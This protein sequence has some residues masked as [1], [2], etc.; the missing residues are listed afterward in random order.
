[1]ILEDGDKIKDLFSSK[2]QSF[3]AELPASLWVG[4][5]Q[6]LSQQVAP[7]PTGS[8][9]ASTSSSSSSSASSSATSSSSSTSSLTSTVSTVG[10]TTV[11]L[12]PVA[13]VASAV[14]LSVAGVFVYDTINNDVPTII[15]PNDQQKIVR[16]D[17][18]KEEVDSIVEEQL[19][20]MVDSFS[21]TRGHVISGSPSNTST[22]I[23][24]TVAEMPEQTITP[25]N[26][27][28]V[29]KNEES[30]VTKTKVEKLPMY[31]KPKGFTLGVY[32]SM[33]LSAYSKN[34]EGN[35]LT[36][37]DPNDFGSDF[38][39]A[40]NLFKMKHSRPISVGLTVSKEI[41]SNLSI[42]TGVI[43]TFLSS[44]IEANGEYIFREKQKFHY[45]GIPIS[46]NYTFFK[47]NNLSLYLSF[48]GMIQKDIKGQYIGSLKRAYGNGMPGGLPNPNM[49]EFNN[50]MSKEKDIHQSN[51]QFS[52]HMNLGITYPLY[53]GLYIYGT[54]G[55][56]YYFDASNKYRT[57]Y[58]DKSTQFDVNAG[59]KLKF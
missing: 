37:S 12:K 6:A 27:I 10:K 56:I 11:W 36:F 1:M 45:L 30:L 41:S 57:I 26:N 32:S 40:D 46:F 50:I 54:V 9:S 53:K 16:I 55:G 42:E 38:V 58:S 49:D 5:D 48:G 7:A 25:E 20:F 8:E 19:P 52:G 34:Q 14:A 59:V 33:G 28:L 39:N 31:S 18:I 29:N 4:I 24:D 22:F 51:P 23:V 2:L 13:A 17:S 43:Y 3:E 44:T 21:P 15:D 35:L 47:Y